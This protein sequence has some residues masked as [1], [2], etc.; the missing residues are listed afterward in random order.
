MVAYKKNSLRWT[1][2][3]FSK[4]ECRDLLQTKNQNMVSTYFFSGSHPFNN[5]I[6]W[7]SVIITIFYFCRYKR[8]KKQFKKP[9]RANILKFITYLHKLL[10]S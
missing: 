1:D 10:S 7:T 9:F 4:I 8:S 5:S 3:D 2:A 6:D